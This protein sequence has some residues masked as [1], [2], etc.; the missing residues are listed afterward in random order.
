LQR[1]KRR[2]VLFGGNPGPR[3]AKGRL[4]CEFDCRFERLVFLPVG[5]NGRTDAVT[6]RRLVWRRPRS[7]SVALDDVAL[8]CGDAILD[9]LALTVFRVAIARDVTF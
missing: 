8:G 2:R 7:R 1:T 3:L 9:K 6:E 5:R 4:D